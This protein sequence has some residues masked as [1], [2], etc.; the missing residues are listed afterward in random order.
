[1]I[2]NLILEDKLI[3]Q[4]WRKPSLLMHKVTHVQVHA[5]CHTQEIYMLILQVSAKSK[6][7][8]KFTKWTSPCTITMLGNY[9]LR[10]LW[11]IWLQPSS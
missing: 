6:M 2:R 5:Q 10:R 7:L 9:F 3:K 11:H 8:M 1:M 4:M